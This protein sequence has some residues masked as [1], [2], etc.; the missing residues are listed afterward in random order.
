MQRCS[1]MISMLL[2]SQGVSETHP[3]ALTPAGARAG[4]VS[5]D[6][7]WC[8]MIFKVQ[9]SLGVPAHWAL[10]KRRLEAVCPSAAGEHQLWRW[11]SL[12]RD[13][14]HPFLL[15]VSSYDRRGFLHGARP[16][17]ARPAP[18]PAPLPVASRALRPRSC[19]ARRMPRR[20]RLGRRAALPPRPPHRLHSRGSRAGALESIGTLQ[21]DACWR[22]RSCLAP[23]RPGSVSCTCWTASLHAVCFA[24]PCPETAAARRAADLMH[25]LWE[26][27]VAVFKAH[28]TTGPGG[29]VMDMFWL[30]D[31]RC[32]LPE[33]HRCAA[34]LRPKPGRYGS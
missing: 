4:D 27:D 16:A 8:F 20:A 28:I 1:R 3:R 12:P 14:Q 30:Y 26:A 25:T 22:W 24:L 23:G 15:Q 7:R 13:F 33:N 11:S 21:S 10:L 18:C 17:R 32:E 29:K 9:L 5:T 34:D 6:G 19:P 2:L 31:N